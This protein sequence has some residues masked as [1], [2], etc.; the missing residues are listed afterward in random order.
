MVRKIKKEKYTSPIVP[1]LA[2]GKE[3]FAECQQW[4]TRRRF[5]KK[6]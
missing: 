1:R 2:L 3:V 5:L 6:T 4:D